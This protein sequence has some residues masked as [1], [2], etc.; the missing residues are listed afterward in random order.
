MINVEDK[1]FIPSLL[2]LNWKD[3]SMELPKKSKKAVLFSVT[4]EWF[5]FF[6]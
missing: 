4:L 6:P 3:I 2:P 5:I 1:L